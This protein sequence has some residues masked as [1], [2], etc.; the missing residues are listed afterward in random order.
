[1]PFDPL[2]LPRPLN[3]DSLA[4]I[5]YLSHSSE[6]ELQFVNS[7]HQ[8]STTTSFTTEAE[9]NASQEDSK[10]HTLSVATA[11]DRDNVKHHKTR[12]RE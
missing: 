1:M 8:S 4:L 3:F 2:F 10:N 6:E 12:S 11:H 9:V 5:P 7:Q